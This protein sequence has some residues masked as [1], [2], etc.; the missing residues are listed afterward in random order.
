MA[1]FAFFLDALGEAALAP[2]WAPVLAWTL[3][4]MA[5]HLALRRWGPRAPSAAYRLAQATLFLL[6]LGLAVA[7][8]AD[9]SWIPSLRQ[10][11]VLVQSTALPAAP[12]ATG[13]AVS[14]A[15]P[16]VPGPSASG[17][18]LLGLAT[19]AAG[20]GAL[21][22]LGALVRQ[23]A[24]L[25][26]LRRA[27]RDAETLDAQADV[28]AAAE[29]VGVRR[30]PTVHVVD[31]DVVPMT[32]GVL[33]PVVVV[34]A[35][36][37]R[38][39]RQLAL[40]HEFQHLRQADPLAHWAEALTAGLFAAHP[41][42]ARL[43]RQC[44]LLREMTCDAAVLALAAYD[45]RS[46]AELV[47]SFAVSPRQRWA[48]GAI[49]MASPLPHVHQRILAMTRSSASP[50]VR[51]TSVLVLGA[52]V[53]GALA[54]T[55]G[56]AIAQP[57]Q[58]VVVVGDSAEDAILII[59]GV[60]VDGSFE[61]IDPGTIYTVDIDRGDVAR[62]SHGAGRVIRVTTRDAAERAGLEPLVVEEAQEDSNRPVLGSPRFV[63]T[64]STFDGGPDTAEGSAIVELR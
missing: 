26:K 2:F 18:T 10:A 55:A 62:A 43:A 20:A 35:S 12:V 44:D 38:H 42:A 54:M 57:A 46:Y 48:P 17:W 34:P 58:A 49:G 11:P 39:A 5:V 14:P 33:R 29:R 19:L 7:V 47:S 8:V 32:L 64:E 59:D 30:V 15:A 61:G 16:A 53:V 45:R 13:V 9:P 22:G 63:V 40:V 21:V 27:L 60:R 41:L 56:G 36:L 1:D 37:D 3:L 23:S 51:L 6:P 4:A 25:R 24:R 50:S 31:S 28:E 52:L